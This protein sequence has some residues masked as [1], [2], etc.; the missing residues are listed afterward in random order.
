MKLSIVTTLYFSAPY[1]AEFYQRVTQTAK[2]IT[3]DYELLFVNDGSPDSSFAAAYKFFK[4]DRHVKI[5]DLSRNFGH[6]KAI[7]TG[8]RHARGE[9]VFLIDSDLEE[10]PELLSKFWQELLTHP[11]W[12]VVYGVQDK[13]QGNLFKK[14]LEV[15][16]YKIFNW[17]SDFDLTENLLLIRLMKKDFVLALVQHQETQVVFAGLCVLTGF[18]Q[19]PLKVIKHSR[20][21]ATTYTWV[22]KWAIVLDGLTSFSTKPLYY[23]AGLGLFILGL[24]LLLIGNVVIKRLFFGVIL[25]GWLSLFI[26]I[27]FLGGL[28][29]FSLGVVGI[30]IAK[31]FLQTK[32]RP[33]TIIRKI[34][35]HR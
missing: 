11:D 33:Y 9:R 19:H 18:S 28:I 34:Y 22:K 21:P 8:L 35:S 17:L 4:T 7:M 31:I 16:F 6:H 5:I 2:K 29:I 12:D 23:M 1:I 15:W 25:E 3:S 10:A 20:R 27:W 26:S 13:R 32:A 30:Y 14:Y 24:S